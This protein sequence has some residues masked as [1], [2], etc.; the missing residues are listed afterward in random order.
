MG[1]LLTGPQPPHTTAIKAL[2][3]RTFKT[4]ART[5]PSALLG[6]SRLKVRE[7]TSYEFALVS[8]AAGVDLDDRGVIREAR[9]ALGGVAHGP[10]RLSG[11]ERALVGVQV[12]NADGLRGALDDDFAEARPRRN[13]GFKAEL[14]KRAVVR[15]L[16]LAVDRA[17]P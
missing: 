1:D 6:G 5:E 11:A 12:A 17:R 2:L 15:T 14:A 10:W 16:Q 13:N 9:V 3:R 7:R 8:V 4:Q